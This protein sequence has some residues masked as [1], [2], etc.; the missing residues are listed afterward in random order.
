M[1]ECV[2]PG[3]GET[4]GRLLE[5]AGATM[6]SEQSPCRVQ[7][8]AMIVSATVQKQRQV[9]T[10]TTSLHVASVFPP[11]PVSTVYQVLAEV[12]KVLM[13]QVASA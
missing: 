13:R 9:A 3:G 6:R 7:Q 11:R 5:R 4:N 12:E 8:N 1:L 2:Y 10:K